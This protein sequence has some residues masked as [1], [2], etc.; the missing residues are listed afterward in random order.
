MLTEKQLKI[1][2]IPVTVLVL[3]VIS[4]GMYVVIHF[5]SKYW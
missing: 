2:M 4:L 3:G 1:I 5:I